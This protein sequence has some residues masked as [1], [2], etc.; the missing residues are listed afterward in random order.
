MPLTGSTAGFAGTDQGAFL[1]GYSGK[2][3]QVDSDGRPVRVYDIGSVPRRIVDTG[4]FLY[5]LTDTRLYVLQGAPRRYRH[6][7]GQ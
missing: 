7:R 5:F 3:V 6:A 1:A 2:I 4:D